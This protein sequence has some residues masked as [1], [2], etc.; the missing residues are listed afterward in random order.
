VVM[1]HVQATPGNFPQIRSRCQR[2]SA[3]I[4]PE[5][6]NDTRFPENSINPGWIADREQ[7]KTTGSDDSQHLFKPDRSSTAPEYYDVPVVVSS[8]EYPD[9]DPIRSL[10]MPESRSWKR[11]KNDRKSGTKEME[12]YPRSGTRW[13]RKFDE[14]SWRTAR[15]ILTAWTTKTSFSEYWL[16]GAVTKIES[17]NSTGT[18]PR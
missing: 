18:V 5:K 11:S 15:K 1:K 13:N 7:L 3:I 14:I 17:G 2:H 4:V 8:Y 9:L 12:V 6:S 10:L 16:N